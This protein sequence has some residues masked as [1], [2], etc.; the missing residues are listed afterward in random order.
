MRDPCGPS[1]AREDRFGQREELSCTREPA[2]ARVCLPH[3]AGAVLTSGRREVAGQRCDVEDHTS[4]GGAS[5]SGD[6][7]ATLD[8]MGGGAAQVAMREAPRERGERWREL[9]R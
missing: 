9:T 1:C 2:L 5:P 8:P 6:H 3:V 4:K 7:D